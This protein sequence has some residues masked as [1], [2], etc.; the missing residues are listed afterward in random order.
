MLNSIT[1]TQ[2]V[3][4]VI[5]LLV[6]YYTFIGFRFYRWEILSLIG[7]KKIEGSGISISTVADFKKSYETENHE[8]YLPKPALE[9]DI[10]PL[11]QAFT[12]EVKAYL[13]E[14]GSSVTANELLQSINLIILKY[15]VL[16][17]AEYQQEL[18]RYIF[19]EVN[20]RYPNLIRQS[21]IKQ[22]LS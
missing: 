3:T 9:I 5:S 1:W 22:L 12:D 11:M 14:S 16:K 13:E 6:C 18:V 17:D 2:Y 21:D 20:T 8:N 15:P 7:I 19:D 4:A 10:S